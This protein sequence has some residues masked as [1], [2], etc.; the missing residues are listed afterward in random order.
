MIDWL[1]L[2]T[3]LPPDRDYLEYHGKKITEDSWR[4]QMYKYMCELDK[5]KVLY[6]PHKFKDS[7]NAKMPFTNIILN[8]KYFESFDEMEIY[9]FAIFSNTEFNLEAINI[10][11]I[12]IAADIPE[13]NV[14]AVIASLH[15]K[16]IQKFRLFYDTIY[17][18]SNPLVRIYDKLREIRDRLKK[19]Y[20]VIESEKKLLEVHKELTRFEIQIRR[21]GLNLKQLMDNPIGLVSYFDKLE[22]IQ[23][24][25]KN[26]CGVMQIMYKQVNRKFR[27]QLEALQNTNLL[28]K[29]KETYTSDVIKWFAQAEPF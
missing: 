24:T 4:V 22:F 7:T 16:G 14:R 3:Q 15:V 1:T 19:G 12:D 26:P 5:A 8:P 29:I 21:P 23:M 18:G 17:A 25:C 13:V 2:T 27:K 11:R 9:I 10:S 28:E 6:Y 20:H